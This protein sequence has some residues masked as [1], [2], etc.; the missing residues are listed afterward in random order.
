MGRGVHLDHGSRGWTLQA[1]SWGEGAQPLPEK[2][3]DGGSL[4]LGASCSSCFAVK[5][6]LSFPRRVQPA[7][8]QM[9]K[10]AEQAPSLLECSP[11][12]G[13]TKGVTGSGAFSGR[14]GFP[15]QGRLSSG[16]KFAWLALCQPLPAGCPWLVPFQK[17][18]WAWPAAQSHLTGCCDWM[19]MKGRF[20]SGTRMLPWPGELK[21]SPGE[22]WDIS[23]VLWT[24]VGS[25]TV[26]LSR[27]VECVWH[28]EDRVWI[29][30]R[31]R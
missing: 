16:K 4:H 11:K 1:W 2:Q 17:C 13:A 29:V 28:C 23:T 22:T 3:E 6:P 8:L 10:A 27:S 30:R 5:A 19:L 12:G 25:G 31:G 14:G 26:P 15:G 18:L 24:A 7:E 20:L 9:L 21:S